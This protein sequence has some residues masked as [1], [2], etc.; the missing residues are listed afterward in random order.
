MKTRVGSTLGKLN[1]PI[2]VTGN[3]GF[4]GAWLSLLLERLEI[5]YFGVGL[6]APSHSLH[7]MLDLNPTEEQ[8]Y[9]NI[10]DGEKISR[11]VANL[12]PSAIVHMAAQPLVIE[13]YK[14]PIETFMTNVMGTAN[15][16]EAATICEETKAVVVITTD[17]VYRNREEG[18]RF[19]E[20]DAI[21]GFDP[22][23]ASKSCAESVTDAWISISKLRNQVK[24]ASCRAGNVIGGGDFAENRL[25]PDLMRTFM[26]SKIPVLRNP[27]STRPWQHAL[28]PLVGYL[29]HLEFLLNGKF[30]RSLNFAP[31]ETSMSVEDVY[32]IAANSWGTSTNYE[33]ADSSSLGTE[34]NQL[35]LNSDLAREILGWESIWGQEGAIRSTVEWWKKYQ[36]SATPQNL[37]AACEID[38]EKIMKSKNFQQK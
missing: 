21:G 4:K 10:N 32:K 23:S 22:Y 38:I 14:N 18:K 34:S 28:D 12:R 13:S 20:N 19:R 37:K 3:T 31:E 16:L 33:C 8:F 25:M 29:M 17:K 5:P 15:I 2:L 35:E 24:I 27:K 7:R 26:E 1:R 9:L 11:L 30:E 6:E 36:L